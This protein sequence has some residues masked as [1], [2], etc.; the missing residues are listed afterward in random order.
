VNGQSRV[1]WPSPARILLLSPGCR[2]RP[3]CRGALSRGSW[4]FRAIDVAAPAGRGTL[5]SFALHP[6]PSS[7]LRSGAARGHRPLSWDAGPRRSSS[8]GPT[9]AAYVLW[10]TRGIRVQTHPWTIPRNEEQQRTPVRAGSSRF[11]SCSPSRVCGCGPRS[12][13]SDDKPPEVRIGQRRSGGGEVV[14][15]GWR[16]GQ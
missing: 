8:V 2:R 4:L 5:A 16:K 15:F 1:H 14:E 13:E 7:A 12:Y 6:R 10:S 9:S 11:R 3:V